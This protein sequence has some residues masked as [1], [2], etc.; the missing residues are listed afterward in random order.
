MG[1]KKTKVNNFIETK[2]ILNNLSYNM[3]IASLLPSTNDI[4]GAWYQ[5]LSKQLNYYLANSGIP[6][7]PIKYD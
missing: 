6:I 7:F 5:S 3:A 4:G 1:S 2:N